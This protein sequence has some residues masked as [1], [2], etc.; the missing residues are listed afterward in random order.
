M[1]FLHQRAAALAVVTTASLLL[2]A[3]TGMSQGDELPEPGADAVRMAAVG[4][5][6]TEADSPDFTAGELGPESWVSYA[7]GEEIEFAGGWAQWGATTAQMAEGAGPVDADVLVILAGTNDSGWNAHDEVG[8][9]LVRIAEAVGA[10]RVVLSS[11]P[12]LDDAPELATELNSY[13]EDLAGEQG[14]EWVDAAAGLRDGERFAPGMASDGVHP[15]QEGARVIG[16]AVREAV[17]G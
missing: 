6:I 3:C 12:P 7:V 14:W 2:S 8:R 9:N 17:S 15:T 10:P 13:L 11:I 4:D 5:S 16:E 1:R